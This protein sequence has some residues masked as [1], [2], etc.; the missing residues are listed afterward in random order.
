MLIIVSSNNITFSSSF[1]RVSTS[2]TDT[3]QLTSAA[4]ESRTDS[5][6]SLSFQ[7]PSKSIATKAEKNA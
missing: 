1:L 5:Y 4:Q 3:M 2:W 7:L 6:M